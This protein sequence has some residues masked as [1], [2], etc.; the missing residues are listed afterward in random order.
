MTTETK[1]NPLPKGEEQK[2]K[3]PYEIVVM[4]EAA[5]RFKVS[6][7]E[8]MVQQASG[9]AAVMPSS[10]NTAQR[11]QFEQNMLVGEIQYMDKYHGTDPAAKNSAGEWKFRA[12]LPASYR[13]A[14]S[15][16]ANCIEVGVAMMEND[17][18]VCGKSACEEAYKAGR[19]ESTTH[20]KTL[21]EKVQIVIE[22]LDKLMPKLSDSEYAI[23]KQK[24]KNRAEVSSR[25][26]TSS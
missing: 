1:V 25:R 9:V 20:P 23:V 16:A 17:G 3:T 5:R 11:A 14:K 4:G 24:L 6:M 26:K 7:W 18:T 2:L 13:T 10:T 8:Q 19:V 22:T 12:Y 21:M 15:V